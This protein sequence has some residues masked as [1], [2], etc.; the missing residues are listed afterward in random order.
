MVA[1]V[2]QQG[3]RTTAMSMRLASRLGRAALYVTVTGIL[4][5]LALEIA[6][7]AYFR[8]PIF[9]LQDWRALQVKVLKSGLKYD[10]LLGWTM[11]SNS[12]APF[13]EL[14]HGIRQTSAGGD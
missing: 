13:I 3:L 1:G 8:L 11:A 5:V 14:D 10:E 7:R 2:Q 4:C 6:L 9:T 12:R